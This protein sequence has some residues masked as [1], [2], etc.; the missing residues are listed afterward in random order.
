MVALLA[1][2]G[3]F[4]SSSVVQKFLKQ[5]A[6]VLVMTVGLGY[7]TNALVIY[8]LQNFLTIFLGVVRSIVMPFN[9]FI[10]IDTL[11]KLFGY[12]LT[13]QIGVW[14]FRAYTTVI[15]FFNER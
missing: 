9:F 1:G 2:I 11:F 14:I 15:Q 6:L 13:F 5:L 10:D 4:L 7:L 8:D 12:G 3:L